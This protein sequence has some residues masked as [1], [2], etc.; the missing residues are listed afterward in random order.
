M[1][2]ISDREHGTKQTLCIPLLSL[3]LEYGYNV[4]SRLP[5][6]T[7]PSKCEPKEIPLSQV[8]FVKGLIIAM[9]KVTSIPL[10]VFQPLRRHLLRRA[11]HRGG[12]NPRMLTGREDFLLRL[13]SCLPGIWKHKV[14]INPPATLVS[15]TLDQS[16][17]SSRTGQTARAES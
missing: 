8:I 14:R 17:I 3:P 6:W 11:E 1:S 4:T 10:D 16:S 9:R 13:V 5:R 12:A 7:V 2:G 15:P